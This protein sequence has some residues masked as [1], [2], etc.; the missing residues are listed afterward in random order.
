M[1]GHEA[2]LIFTLLATAIV[3]L[4]DF[5]PMSGGDQWASGHKPTAQ[6]YKDIN[7]VS[8]SGQYLRCHKCDSFRHLN[9]NCPAESTTN[10]VNKENGQP[11]RCLCCDSVRH[12]MEKC[13]HTWESKGRKV[14]FVNESDD[15]DYEL[16]HEEPEDDLAEYRVPVVLF[17]R[18]KQ[19]LQLLGQEAA[20][21][22]VLDSG[23]VSTVCG[24]RW[25]DMFLDQLPDSKKSQV[26]WKDSST[27]FQFGGEYSLKSIGKVVLPGEILGKPVLIE[28]DV[29]D[30]D[31]PLLFSNKALKA[32]KATINYVTDEASLMGQNTV[33]NKTS[34]GHH[35]VSLLPNVDIA[36]VNAVVIQE[37]GHEDKL[38]TITKLHRQ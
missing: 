19:E 27:L 23:C 31:I 28:T 21:S 12:L 16:R 15:C 9:F 25:L 36:R 24:K 32:M 26:V 3:N 5:V 29:V 20:A 37:L 18:D 35:C 1:V 38:K 30:S 8:K 17:T 10:P 4:T 6:N 34:A 14:H 22:G 7:P 13:P 2:E 11:M 33:L